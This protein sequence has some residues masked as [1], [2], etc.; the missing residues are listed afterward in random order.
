[1]LNENINTFILKYALG[2]Q[3]PNS[4]VFE[5]I[6]NFHHDLFF[7]LVI[8]CF[9]VFYILIRTIFL[10]SFSL[11]NALKEERNVVHSPVLEITWTLIPAVILMF[12]A[13][14]S[15]SLLYSIDEIINPFFTMKVIGHQWYWS[16]EFL[17][18]NMLLNEKLNNENDLSI[19]N[20]Y[21]LAD[22]ELF[23]PSS[24]LLDVDNR[25]FLPVE[26]NVHLLLTSTDILHSWAIPQLGIKLDACPGRLNQTSLYISREDVIFGQ[27]SEICG[28][29]HGFMPIGINSTYLFDQSSLALEQESFDKKIP[30]GKPLAEGTSANGKEPKGDGPSAL[31]QVVTGFTV[32]AVFY[33]GYDI[34]QQI[35]KLLPISSQE[36][37]KA[38]CGLISEHYIE[39]LKKLYGM[40]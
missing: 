25:I 39:I 27:C 10:Y 35:S 9:F 2:F 7:F 37:F 21:I 3:I 33:A 1:M 14:P 34:I 19:V 40:K 12:V 16:Y 17:D 26:A 29:N 22:N 11:K 32:F 20:S 36:D 31:K 24:R 15:F 38:A 4:P 28:I 13:I 8:I 23:E 18:F 6:V 5:G 30:K